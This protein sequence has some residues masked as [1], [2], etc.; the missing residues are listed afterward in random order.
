M[1]NLH[2]RYK[3]SQITNEGITDTEMEIVEFILD[4]I[5]DLT[6]F[7]DDKNRHNYMNSKGDF[8]FRQDDKYDRLMI[9]YQD[10]WEVLGDKYLLEYGDIQVIIKDMIENIY[11]MMVGKPQLGYEVDNVWVEASYKIKIGTNILTFT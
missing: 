5:K 1:K 10:F 11:K 8:I 3:I 6:I 4:K 2:K 9:R 7:I